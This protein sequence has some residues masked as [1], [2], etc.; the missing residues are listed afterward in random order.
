MSNFGE[1]LLKAMKLCEGIYIFDGAQSFI[2]LYP[3]TTENISGYL[4]FFS[5]ENKSVLTVGS[6][7]DQAFE[8]A[9]KNTREITVLDICPFTKEYFYLKK[10]ALIN[11]SR[12]EFKKFFCYRNY[13]KMF[14]YNDEAF[15]KEVFASFKNYLRLEDYESYLFWDEL[16]QSFSSVDIRS[17]LFDSDEDIFSTLESTLSYLKNDTNYNEAK[18]KLATLKPNFI[19]GDIFLEK[20]TK[21][22]DAILLSNIG[23]YTSIS[24]LYEL[25]SKLSINL[26]DFGQMLICY[27]YE[28]T[29]DSKYY[30]N[31]AEIY[32]LKKLFAIFPPSCYLENFAGI[33][34][35][36]FKDNVKDAIFTY[37]KEK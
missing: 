24:K 25:F 32:D 5:L 27:L 33:D 12:S 21:S 14:K 19:I 1:R 17:N 7:S 16:F 23:K 10:A 9:L 11:L 30:N 22:Y 2:R 34:S 3:F 26:N 31:Y 18:K 6:S 4:P 35:F 15:S 29:K 13:P 28:T 37:K 36:I 8:L 20:L